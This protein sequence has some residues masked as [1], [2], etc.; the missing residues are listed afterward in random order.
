MRGRKDGMLEIKSDRE[1][2][3]ATK[4]LGEGKRAEGWFRWK[5]YG[6]VQVRRSRRRQRGKD[7]NKSK[8][9]RGRWEVRDKAKEWG[10]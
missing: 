7:G 8:T 1:R 4:E 9:D 2:Q 5:G 6:E 3:T 10:C